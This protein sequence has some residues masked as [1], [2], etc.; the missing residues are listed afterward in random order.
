MCVLYK[1]FSKIVWNSINRDRIS[2]IISINFPNNFF[3]FIYL[4]IILSTCSCHDK[5]VRNEQEYEKRKV[6]K[7]RLS[8]F[9]KSIFRQVTAF[10]RLQLLVSSRASDYEPANRAHGPSTWAE[11]MVDDYWSATVT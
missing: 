11:H 3:I 7:M 1:S 9:I 6:G 4:I 10:R 5:N 2:K 8:H